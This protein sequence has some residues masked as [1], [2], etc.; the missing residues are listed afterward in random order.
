MEPLVPDALFQ[1]D[2]LAAGVF[3]L[4]PVQLKHQCKFPRRGGGGLD[5]V[6]MGSIL[7]QQ[8]PE[9]GIGLP[10]HPLAVPVLIIL[11][12]LAGIQRQQPHGLHAPQQISQ[13][14]D[15]PPDALC[16]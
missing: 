2:H 12:G 11:E 5:G 8:L 1:P 16:G 13:G 14:H 3:F 4:L 9:G 15:L 10:L 6:Q 7:P